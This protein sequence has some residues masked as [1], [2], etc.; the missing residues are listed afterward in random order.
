MSVGQIVLTTLKIPQAIIASTQAVVTAQNQLKSAD[1]AAQQK[2]IEAQGTADAAVMKA[3]GEAAAIQVKASTISA[4]GGDS[5]IHLEAVRKW[6]GKLPDY[7][8]SGAPIPFIGN[9]TVAK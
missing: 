6:D 1:F 7:V 2:R 4:Q 9:S 3:K 8:G 5:Y